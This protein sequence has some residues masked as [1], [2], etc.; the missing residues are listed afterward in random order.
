M[1]EKY[2]SFFAENGITSTSANHLCNLA[3]EYASNAKIDITGINFVKTS[4]SSLTANIKPIVL[5][6]A[7]DNVTT[8]SDIFDKISKA[9][10]FVAYMQEAIKAK[11]DMF[12]KITSMSVAA[13]C[14]EFGNTFP[15]TPVREKYKTFDDFFSELDIKSKTE[16]Y[17]LEAE[18]AVI[19]KAIHPGGSFHNA[20]QQMFEAAASPAYISGDKVYHRD[21]SVSKEDVE[22][23]YFELQKKHRSIEAKLNSIKNSIDLKTKEYN[24]SVDSEYAKKYN[25][26]A[27]QVE[28]LNNDFTN[29]KNAELKRI[30]KLKIVI[31]NALKETY[32]FLNNL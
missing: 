27:T 2:Q 9:N 29:W 23:L 18:A 20:R 26:Y 16:Y 31:P 7:V 14:Q 11:N 32:D 17:A 12:A 21:I 6:A 24:T 28:L 1:L 30:N 13:Y 10:A 3:R 25:I 15:E 4:V 8:I 22:N 5:N 19:G